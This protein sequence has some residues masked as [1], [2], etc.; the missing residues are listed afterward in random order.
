MKI[1]KILKVLII[2]LILILTSC[3]TMYH[4]AG[5]TGGYSEIIT[6]TD[7]F[8]V[9]FK[10]NRFTSHEKVI[11]YALKR[12]SELTIQNGYRYFILT[13]SIDQTRSIGYLNTHGN[14]QG[15]T[16]RYSY[17]NFYNSYLN[18]SGSTTTYSGVI[19]KPGITIGI[20]CFNEKPEGLDVIDAQYYLEKN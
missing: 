17:S 5:L 15:S 18:G 1:T 6:S 19:H 11:Q 16:T 4:S 7:S 12:A 2:P 3:V 10:G 20:K 14:I 13:S 8:L 9:T